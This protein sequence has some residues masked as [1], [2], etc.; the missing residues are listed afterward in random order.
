[1][2]YGESEWNKDLSKLG[3]KSVALGLSGNV[4]QAD[5]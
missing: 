4:V 5:Q 1:M 3:K 2:V